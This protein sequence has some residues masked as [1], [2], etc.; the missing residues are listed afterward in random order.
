MVSTNITSSLSTLIT[1]NHILH[2]HGVLDA[3]GHISVRNPENASTFFPSR[4]LAPALVSSAS[5]IVELNVADASPVDP[6]SPRTFIEKYIHSEILKRFDDVNSVVHS[7]SPQVLPYTVADVPLKAVYHISGF[8]GNRGVPNFDA[9][10]V[11][12]PGD[13]Q[14]LLIRNTK[15]GMAL[16]NT[17]SVNSTTSEFLD[18]PLVLMGGHG[19]SLAATDIEEA[20]FFTIYAQSDAEVE[21][22]T[23]ELEHGFSGAGGTGVRYLTRLKAHDAWAANRPLISRPWE[24]WHREV[25]T[26]GRGLYVHELEE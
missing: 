7:H 25:Q 16:A 24:L 3:Y 1:A 18:P 11:Y 10:D 21:S 22:S 20:V 15:L 5:D 17:F 9:A 4:S 12:E 2:Y 26:M 23:I 8:L 14:D 6:N 19:F 13:S